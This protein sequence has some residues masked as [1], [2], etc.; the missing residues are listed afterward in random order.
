MDGD[1]SLE[2]SRVATG[3]VLQGVFTELRDQ[4]VD[5]RG[6]LL[7]AN[8]VLSGYGA[9]A[10][11][12]PDEVAAATLDVLERHVPAAVPGVVFLSGGQPDLEATR[13][14]DAMA[15]LGPHPWPLSF[16]FSRAL[17]SA[18]LEVW[19]GRA[20]AVEAAQDTFAHRLRM[21]AAAVEGGYTPELET[22]A[23]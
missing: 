11:A 6:V 23:A 7:K 13:N 1:H 4:R 3:R 20:D 17:H 9:P 5:Y 14:L 2:Q 8:M 15:R 16:S 10:P 19:G 22:A 12:P 18:A 21:N